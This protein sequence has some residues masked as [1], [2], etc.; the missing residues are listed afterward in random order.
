MSANPFKAMKN[1][2]RAQA[3]I[4]R[5]DTN[6]DFKVTQQ[7]LDAILANLTTTQTGLGRKLTRVNARS[8]AAMERMSARSDKRFDKILSTGQNIVDNRYG[9]VIGSD[10]QLFK[11]TARLAKSQGK[12]NK[13]QVKAGELQ[14]RG[15]NE[16]MD[17]LAS[18][19]QTAAD[20]GNYELA[21]ALRERQTADAET[22]A[23]SKLALQQQRL[24][25]ELNERY[26][27]L[28]TRLQSGG[29]GGVGFQ[30]AASMLQELAASGDT[31]LA[32]N[33]EALAI[34][35]D[36]GP[37]QV[38]QLR[39]MAKALT[40]GGGGNPTADA[41]SEQY[42]ESPART[43]DPG[44][45]AAINSET[46]KAFDPKKGVPSA[47]EALAIL[48][49][50]RGTDGKFVDI[51]GNEIDE[52]IVAAGIAYVQSTWM[53]IAKQ[54]GPPE[55]LTGPGVRPMGPGGRGGRPS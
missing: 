26:L 45:E 4:L 38:A 2:N 18:A 37:Q 5:R 9:T 32:G 48:D 6:A 10:P 27:R 28:Q 33:V 15:A 3:K 16:A 20:S 47:D 24:D 55:T 39:E 14:M 51:E 12:V 43:L 19:A 36:L 44:T 49:W 30:A 35:Y 17:I 53:R 31:S 52:Q 41:Y 25:A 54:A 34:Q 7:G 40:G 22:I 50:Q 29:Q 23:A 13:G 46:W 42:G 11:G 8:L 21:Q 1:A